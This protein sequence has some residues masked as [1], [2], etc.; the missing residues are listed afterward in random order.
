MAET[1]RLIDWRPVRKGKL[2]GF[3]SVELPI[4]LRIHDVAVLHG[5]TGPWAALPTKAEL[6]GDRRQRRDV[7]GQPSYARVLS[8]CTKR[9]EDAFS[10]RVVALVQA[11]HPQ[12][13]V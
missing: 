1:L 6:D 12:D 9:L 4:G 13:L 10:A 3:A 5:K 8:W 2:L 7:E 11:R